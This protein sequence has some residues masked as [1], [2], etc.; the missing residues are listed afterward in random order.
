MKAFKRNFLRTKRI[1]LIGG[2]DDEVIEPWQSS[3]FGFH[4][5]DTDKIVLDV[6]ETPA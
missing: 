6:R 1:V 2:E 3:L 4:Q 5:I